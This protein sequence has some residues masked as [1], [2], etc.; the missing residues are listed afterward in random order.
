MQAADIYRAEIDKRMHYSNLQRSVLLAAQT[1]ISI[2][3]SKATRKAAATTLSD[4]KRLR[5][6]LLRLPMA[7]LEQEQKQEQQKRTQPQHQEGQGWGLLASS[8]LA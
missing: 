1:N 5:P 6:H 7:L 8:L 3:D 4:C 2:A